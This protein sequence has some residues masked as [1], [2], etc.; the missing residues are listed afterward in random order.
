MRTAT[1][2]ILVATTISP[3]FAGPP[4]VTDDPTPTPYQHWEIYAFGNGSK[5]RGGSGGAA[6]LDFNYGAGENLQLSMTL[7]MGYDNPTDGGSSVS[8]GNIELAAKYRFLHQDSDGWDVSVF[9][10]VFLPAGL[11]KVGERHAS[12]LL[13]VWI[14]KSWSDW[15]TFGGGGCVLNRGGGSKNFC[16]ASWAVT[17]QVLRDL[18]LGVEIYHRSA[19]EIGG[20]ESTGASVG[21]SYDLD[22]NW[23]VLASLGPGVQNAQETNR[24]SWYAALGLTF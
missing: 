23:H 7:P 5:S 12:L 15:S 8:L 22:D 1:I 3:A 13:P 19:D 17:R 16:V 21:A 4:Y 20:R 9:P 18:Q 10:R 2:A 14:G 24:Y 6:G 11:A